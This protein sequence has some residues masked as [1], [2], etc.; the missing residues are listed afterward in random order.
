MVAET[1]I[2]IIFTVLFIATL[3]GGVLLFKNFEKLFGAD[4]DF[5][6][7]NEGAR[8]LNKVQ[9][10]VLWLHMLGLTGGFALLLH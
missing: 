9:A 7:D 2:R 4:P 8:G 3:L 5:P 1:V 6:G 10:I